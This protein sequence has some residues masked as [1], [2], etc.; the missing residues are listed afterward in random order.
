MIH[1]CSRLSDFVVDIAMVVSSTVGAPVESLLYR[2]FLKYPDIS[3]IWCN[4]RG[5]FWMNQL[6]SFSFPFTKRLL[7][8]LFKCQPATLLP[9]AFSFGFLV[10]NLER[11]VNLS[12]RFGVSSTSTILL[13]DAT[14]LLS[15]VGEVLKS[16]RLNL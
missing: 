8:S 12:R 9:L 15:C 1:A 14:A 2:S 4:G 13:V 16:H 5:W 11:E 3:N 10:G 7:E 6:F